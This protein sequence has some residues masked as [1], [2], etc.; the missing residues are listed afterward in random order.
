MDK[1]SGGK[2]QPYNSPGHVHD[3]PAH[4]MPD[5][6]GG[7]MQGDTLP[8]QPMGPMGPMAPGVPADQGIF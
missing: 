2:F 3:H 1:H 8:G 7:M 6:S 4:N 5:P